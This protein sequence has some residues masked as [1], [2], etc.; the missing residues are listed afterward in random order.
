MS[1][2]KERAVLSLNHHRQHFVPELADAPAG[3]LSRQKMWFRPRRR[4]RP[5][6]TVPAVEPVSNR[7]SG[8][9]G[10]IGRAKCVR[11]KNTPV[12]ADTPPDGPCFLEGS[13]SRRISQPPSF[14]LT[15]LIAFY[16]CRRADGARPKRIGVP[17]FWETHLLP[18][19][20][21]R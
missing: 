12:G 7:P 19:Y 17:A 18:C 6:L 2:D 1:K 3:S 11:G 21:C 8:Q 20:A 15:S 9:R 14:R 5:E 10:G 16:S 4:K 13:Q